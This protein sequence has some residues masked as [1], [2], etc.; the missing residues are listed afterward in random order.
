M[1]EAVRL[2]G[3]LA[4]AFALSLLATPLARSLAVRTGFLDHPVGFK[5]HSVPT[6]YLGGIAVLGGW[7]VAAVVFGGAFSDFAALSVCAVGLLVV[8]TLDDRF[9]LPIAPRLIAVGLAGVA[10]WALGDGWDVLHSDVGN[11]GLTLLWVIAVTNAFNLMDNIDGSGATVSAVSAAGIA[12]LALGRSDVLLAAFAIALT[13]A[14]LGF[15]PWNLAKPS[16]IFLGDGGSM[17]I[18]FLVAAMVM[19]IPSAGLGWATVPALALLVAVPI[20]D[21]TLVV[22][23][24]Y[25][26][27]QP[28]LQGGR[29]HLTHRLLS[30]FGSE[31]RVAWI[32]GTAQALFC[33]FAYALSRANVVEVSITTAVLVAGGLLYLASL[34]LQYRDAARMELELRRAESSA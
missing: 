16:R 30:R 20:F 24:R 7:L 18:G 33:G 17:P 8:G 27:R 21:T 29:D 13:G 14:T 19:A 10:L 12:A 6:P 28:I 34:E 2:G 26:R 4:A 11:L 1:A 25:R 5:G 9:R 22:L 15:L 23:S 31:R 32:L 3:A